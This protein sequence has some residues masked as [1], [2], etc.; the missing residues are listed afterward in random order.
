MAVQRERRLPADLEPVQVRLI[1]GVGKGVLPD[2][3][4]VFVKVMAFPRSRDRWRYAFRALPGPHEAHLLEKVRAGG[5]PAPEPLA[6]V[7]RRRFG[8]PSA[9]LLVT[10]ALPVVDRELEP[11]AV[12]LLVRDLFE[13]GLYHPD[14][15]LGNFASLADGGLA[16][17]DL[18]SARWRTSL[19]LRERIRMVARVLYEFC[20]ERA[21]EAL[22]ALELLPEDAMAEARIQAADLGR[23]ALLRRVRRCLL[24]STEFRRTFGLGQVRYQRR[25]SDG[26]GMRPIVVSAREGRC[27]WIGDRVLELT[28]DRTPSLGAF[29]H[30]SWWFPGK[31]SVY[32]ADVTGRPAD[33]ELRV[34]LLEGYEDYLRLL[35]GQ[36]PR[37]PLE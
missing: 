26:E 11:E 37:N 6:W 10:R 31:P 24:T 34:T 1:R 2:A 14:L 30:K 17:L 8:I 5:V 27:L 12:G 32:I 21:D 18:Q 33:E 19:P 29:V 28:R 23:Q 35:S 13:C 3:G 25:S 9:S 7:G 16:T 20:S 15:N 36:H 4:E 22:A